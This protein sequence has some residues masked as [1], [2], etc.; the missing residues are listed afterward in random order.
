MLLYVGCLTAFIAGALIPAFAIVLGRVTS[1]FD[2]SQ[3]DKI[4]DKMTDL[5][6]FVLVV[7]A[8]I[9]TMSYIYYAFFQQIAEIIAID[10]RRQYLRSL[11]R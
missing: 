8:L 9:W 4:L 5:L 2:P 6:K 11:L 10:L 1:S 7:V 3:N